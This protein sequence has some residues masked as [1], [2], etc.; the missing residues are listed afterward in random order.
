VNT[1]RIQVP[2]LEVQVAAKI[3]VALRLGEEK[4]SWVDSYAKARGS[5]RQVVLESA[6][7]AFRGLCESGVPDPS[8]PEPKLSSARL[9]VARSLVKDEGDIGMVRQRQLNKNRGAK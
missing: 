9:Q 8:A 1:I 2:A 7:D 6:V 5:S 4:L 3:A